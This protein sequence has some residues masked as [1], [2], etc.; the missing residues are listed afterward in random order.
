VSAHPDR[1]RTPDVTGEPPVAV[2]PIRDDDAVFA[3]E[4]PGQGLDSFDSEASFGTLDRRAAVECTSDLDLFPSEDVGADDVVAVVGGP[5]RVASQAEVAADGGVPFVASVEETLALARVRPAVV[6]TIPQRAPTRTARQL[7]RAAGIVGVLGLT[8]A[9]ILLWRAPAPSLAPSLV[10]GDTAQRAAS[11]V[12]Q[13]PLPALVVTPTADPPTMI[14]P[15]APP[16]PMTTPEPL[17]SVEPR[18]D[19]GAV[20]TPPAPPVPMPSSSPTPAP[21][22]RFTQS[23]STDITE[24]AGAPVSAERAEPPAIAALA[25]AKALSPEPLAAPLSAASPTLPPVAPAS[26][27]VVGEAVGRTTATPA[28]APG[29]DAED[30]ETVLTRYRSAFGNLDAEAVS[31]VWPNADARALARAFRGLEAQGIAFDACAIQVTGASAAASCGGTVHYVTKVGS[32]EP[33]TERRRWQFTLGKV[34]DLWM[35]QTVESR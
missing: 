20:E 8:T 14:E 12:P 10:V 11:A 25:G 33:R 19:P 32:K 34:R 16:E 29:R 35:I 31:Q 18:A 30:I 28:P 9:G 24:T 21:Q 26:A 22:E 7:A 13:E 4:E 23:A 6:I 3:D 17:V 5:T 27:P 15:T 1:Q 2:P